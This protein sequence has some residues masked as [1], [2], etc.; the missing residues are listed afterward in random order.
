[1]CQEYVF[2]FLQVFLLA[3]IF[4][5]LAKMPDSDEEFEDWDSALDTAPRNFSLRALITE[6]KD[7]L[8]DL[9]RL[10]RKIVGNKTN[11]PN[12]VKGSRPNKTQEEDIQM[13]SK[14]ID[15][16][17]ILKEKEQFLGF[18]S[19]FMVRLVYT[20]ALVVISYASVSQLGLHTYNNIKEN[21]IPHP[22]VVNV[23]TYI[24]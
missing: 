2:C 22:D 20:L 9:K 8:K 7:V 19:S 13:D 1:M 4:A 6:L 17:K 14:F 18:L 21:V 16:N 10:N 3:V 12:A 5:F 11:N 24:Y 15:S 23:S